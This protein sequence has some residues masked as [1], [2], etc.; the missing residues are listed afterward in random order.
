M[1][2]C[3][4]CGYPASC[5]LDHEAR[6]EYPGDRVDL[7]SIVPERVIAWDRDES[8]SCEAGTPGCPILHRDDRGG[9]ETW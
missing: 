9:C 6:S 1:S 4:Y 2:R 5:R 7:A 3:P 8:D